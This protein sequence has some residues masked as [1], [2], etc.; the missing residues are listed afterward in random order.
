M[1]A[2]LES[3]AHVCACEQQLAWMHVAHVAEV[4]LRP[5]ATVV[6]PVE[7]LLLPLP[8]PLDAVEHCVAQDICTQV[9]MV[10][11]ADVHAAVILA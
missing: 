5:H 7:P 8:P 10:W 4:K 1:V 2:Q 9:E 3:V 6:P 11:S